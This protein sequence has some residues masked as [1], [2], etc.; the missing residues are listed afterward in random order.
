M[1]FRIFKSND[2][3]FILFLLISVFSC[4]TDNY[5]FLKKGVKR[6]FKNTSEKQ[7]SALFLL[8]NLATKEHYK[9][10][11]YEKIKQLISLYHLNSDTLE[12]TLSTIGP[13][14][15]M[16][17]EKDINV[18]SVKDLVDDINLTYSAL[19]KAKWKNK[20]READFN[21]YVL[22]YKVNKAQLE[23]WRD[24]VLIDYGDTAFNFN[25]ITKATEYLVKKTTALRK[26][27]KVIPSTN[28]PDLPYSSLKKI[29]YGSC[30]E[31]SD[32][33]SFILR[34]HAIPCVQDFT[35]NYTNLWSGHYWNA[36][37]DE[38][39]NS[40]P[41]VI[42]LE[43]DTLGHFK[44]ECY[45]LG[46]VYRNTFLKNPQSHAVLKGLCN[47]LPPVFNNEFVMDVTNEYVKTRNISIPITDKT[48]N[49]DII[50]LSVYDNK[51]WNPI[52]W[53][54]VVEN[55]R[56]ATFEKIGIGSVYIPVSIS[57]NGKTY[58][59]YPFILTENGKIE[60][61][62]PNKDSLISLNI[63]RKYPL[64]S[65]IKYFINRMNG[66]YF[67]VA[68]KIDFSDSKI[69]HRIENLEDEYFKE[70]NINL[71][72]TYRYIRYLSPSGSYCNVGEL[73]FYDRNN[74]RLKGEIIANRKTH[75]DFPD[76]NK[77]K[78]FDGDVLTFFH[79]N[80]AD[81][82]WIGMDFKVSQNIG[83]IRY[84]PRIGNNIIV[85]GNVYEV[86]YWDNRWISLGIKEAK[87]YVLIYENVPSNAIYFIH[88]HS[89]GKEERI[90]TYENG[91]QVWW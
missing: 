31:L 6:E 51:D 3:F 60:I 58:L 2:L 64:V 32:Y 85:P 84:I 57:T 25:T 76:R 30:K 10:K 26:K 61:K 40:V 82:C 41:F 90:F 74:N 67:E 8:E 21:N 35:P 52:A 46:K 44:S 43:V 42:P 9:G 50:Y 87:N 59:N 72:K 14:L 17:L 33:I 70:V 1:R 11:Q 38:S 55:N 53:G 48:T 91:K 81:S 37:I 20:I 28:L 27:I 34:A 73:E 83:K 54:Q 47:Y 16:D 89:G 56:N 78:A 88:N 24:S 4:N 63:L 5:T 39:G 80:S 23:D 13:L 71:K 45:Q 66:G 22:P 49:D 86:Y 36:I 68:N 65:R 18:I 19:S 77:G 62:K 15:T 79:A 75:P 7:R 12:K 29:P 69:I